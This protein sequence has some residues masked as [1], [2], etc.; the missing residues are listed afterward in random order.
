MSLYNNPL[1]QLNLN[2]TIPDILAIDLKE[3]QHCVN[4]PQFFDPF[5]YW[6]AL[7]LLPALGYCKLCCYEH[8]NS[9]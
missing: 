6:W 4:V 5:I 1:N 7:R 8:L 9:K 3:K 2:I